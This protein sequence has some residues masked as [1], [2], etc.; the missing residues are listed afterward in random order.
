MDGGAGASTFEAL[1]FTKNLTWTHEQV[2]TSH[3]EKRDIE[4]FQVATHCKTREELKHSAAHTKQNATETCALVL[5]SLADFQEERRLTDP[6]MLAGAHSRHASPLRR[7][8][9]QRDAADQM[10]GKC[11]HSSEQS[12]PLPCRR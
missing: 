2:R 5:G 10:T 1:S 12:L 7:P 8:A 6:D 11:H 9:P 4:S 3:E